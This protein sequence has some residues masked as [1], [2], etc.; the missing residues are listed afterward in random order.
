MRRRPTS[1]ELANL[2]AALAGTALSVA[3]T[4]RRPAGMAPVTRVG[5]ALGG[6][7]L[8]PRCRAAV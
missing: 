8:P 1:I 2:A 5:S 4:G 6:L 7:T 3:L